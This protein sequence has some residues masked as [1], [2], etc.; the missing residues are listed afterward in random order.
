MTT[1]YSLQLINLLNIHHPICKIPLW[2][3]FCLANGILA[4]LVW[5]PVYSLFENPLSYFG[6]LGSKYFVSK[7]A[8]CYETTLGI[9]AQWKRCGTS[10]EDNIQ[11]V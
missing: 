2:M 8:I 3:V 1:F 7:H 5:E 9:P 4:L 6:L 10:Q 11:V